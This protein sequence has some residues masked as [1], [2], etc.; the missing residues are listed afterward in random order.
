MPSVQRDPRLLTEIAAPEAHQH[1]RDVVIE[2]REIV[3]IV[4]SCHEVLFLE[5][6]APGTDY[7]VVFDETRPHGP[8]I[9]PMH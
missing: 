3:P 8:Q 9:A 1:H 5:P 6:A 4:A 7:S 2:V